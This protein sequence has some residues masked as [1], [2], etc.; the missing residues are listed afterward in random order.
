MEAIQEE[1]NA[2]NLE[3]VLGGSALTP[4]LLN[5]TQRIERSA[6]H[7]VPIL[8][9]GDVLTKHFIRLGSCKSHDRFVELSPDGR[10]LLWRKANCLLINDIVILYFRL[11]HLRLILINK[12]LYL[13][14][15]PFKRG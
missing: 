6:T 8:Q 12:S 3:S 14:F 9:H 2:V 13:P 1:I 7:S 11:E 5:W 10:Y 4:D 15:Y